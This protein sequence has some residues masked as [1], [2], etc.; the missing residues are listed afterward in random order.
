MG[1]LQKLSMSNSGGGVQK[2][3]GSTTRQAV[4][5]PFA[6]PPMKDLSTSE[7]EDALSCCNIIE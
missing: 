4:K 7:L 3:K 2:H 1:L 5:S 6:A